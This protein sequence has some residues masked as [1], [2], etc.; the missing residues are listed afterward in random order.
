MDHTQY[1]LIIDPKNNRRKM[2]DRNWSGKPQQQDGKLGIEN[3]GR[4]MMLID[5]KMVVNELRIPAEIKCK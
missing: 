4:E 2:C 3:G 1:N 5:L